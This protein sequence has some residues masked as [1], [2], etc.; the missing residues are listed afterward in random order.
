MKFRLQIP[1]LAYEVD[2]DGKMEQMD[3]KAA[4][5]R[6]RQA[7]AE[8]AWGAMMALTK[9]TDSI[10]LLADVETDSKE[11]EEES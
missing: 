8:V 4:P 2:E 3:V 5:L 11:D 1:L 6:V 7:M 9:T 10:S